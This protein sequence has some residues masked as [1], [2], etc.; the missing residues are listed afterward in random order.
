MCERIGSDH[1]VINIGVKDLFDALAEATRARDLPGM[2]DVDS[3]LLLACREVKEYADVVISGE[4]ADEIFLGYPWFHR[5]DLMYQ[6]CFPWSGSMELR[7]NIM[8]A[9]VSHLPIE[10][11]TRDRYLTA[12][13]TAP[14]PVS[15]THLDVYKR[16]VSACVALNMM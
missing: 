13:R 6:D 15:Y 14:V 4:C 12:M 7:R 16:Q 9:A 5:E 11:Y 8:G 1:H 2:A 3:S 10:E